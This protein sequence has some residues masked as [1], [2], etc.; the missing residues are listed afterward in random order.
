MEPA[1]SASYDL[2]P[3]AL[4]RGCPLDTLQLSKP[5]TRASGSDSVASLGPSPR[6]RSVLNSGP[7][8][9]G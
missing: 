6:V 7:R 4:K 9:R 5:P 8:E 2:S 3:C 1:H